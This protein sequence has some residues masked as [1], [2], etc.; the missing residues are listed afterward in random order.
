MWL[1]SN[2]WIFMCH[3]VLQ[4]VSQCTLPYKIF[5][6]PF[7]HTIIH[8]S[9]K[10]YK[11]I[12][13]ISIQYKHKYYKLYKLNCFAVPDKHMQTHIKLFI[14]KVY[15]N[16]IYTRYKHNHYIILLCLINKEMRLPTLILSTDLNSLT[17]LNIL[18]C[19][20]NPLRR[21]LT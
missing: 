8:I 15:K 12:I 5:Y 7:V 21:G 18:G 11:N 19:C 10:V 2:H 9:D 20:D 16:I 17:N 14:Q 3:N 13:Y 1:N 6:W 4:I